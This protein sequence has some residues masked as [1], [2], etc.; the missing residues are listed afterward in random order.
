[1]C[2][3]KTRYRVKAFTFPHSATKRLPHTTDFASIETNP[4]RTER[5][6]NS[7]TGE[8]KPEK[9]TNAN[10]MII[11]IGK[12]AD[13]CVYF[14]ARR[15]DESPRGGVL[16][17]LPFHCFARISLIPFGIV[18]CS[19]NP[20]PVEKA[21]KKAQTN[22]IMC[23]FGTHACVCMCSFEIICECVCLIVRLIV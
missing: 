3:Y 6:K 1:M 14:F 17:S 12:S 8:K 11:N 5:Q 9:S 7:Q 13:V 4:S 2:I 10:K 22:F 19:W 21:M 15:R 20:N 16:S 18:W 23:G